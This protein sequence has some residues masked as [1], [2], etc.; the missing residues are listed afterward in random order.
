MHISSPDQKRGALRQLLREQPFIVA[1]AVHDVFGLRLVEQAGYAS[2]CISG[3][4]LSYG[5]LGIPDIGLLTLTECVEHC[6]RLARA[7]A[8]PITADADA[9]YGNARGV[10]YAVE[11][12][13]EAGA[14]G[15]NIEDQIVPRRH[16]AQAGKEVVSVRE[17]AGKIAAAR[18]ARRDSN[19]LII[20]RTDACV[21]E[22]IEQVIDRAKAYQ[23]AGADLLLPMA[24][25]SEDDIARLV[26]AVEIPVTISA[27]TGLAPSPAAAGASLARLRE[28]GVRR[29]SLTT[30]LPGACAA[31]MQAALVALQA[32]DEGGSAPG[33]GIGA[34]QAVKGA[35]GLAALFGAEAQHAFESE[36]LR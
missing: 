30:L 9:G 23:D 20:A 16:G 12:F 34:V 11:L 13:E 18:D 36:L 2:A 10:H 25:R 32:W 33:S 27:A 35:N 1:P 31:G 7:S 5:L 29:V 15:V 8:I 6:R 28:L 3:A 24:P 14:A 26:R 21:V 4:M 19:F 22:S 17:M